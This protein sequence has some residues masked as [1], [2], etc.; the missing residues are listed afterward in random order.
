M[1]TKICFLVASVFC[2]LTA[3]CAQGNC[4]SQTSS[5][6]AS[7]NAAPTTA[8][9]GASPATLT[10]AQAEVQTNNTSNPQDRIRVF[11]YDGSLQCGMGAAIPLATMAKDLGDI[12]T[13][14]SV[15]KSDGLMHMQMCGSPTGKANVYE[16]DSSQLPAAKKAGFREW[17]LD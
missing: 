10:A 11:K 15:N 8:A 5:S 14:S 9:G 12:K 16:I 2:L 4:R 1:S 3:A 6:N 17:T 13:F 7:P